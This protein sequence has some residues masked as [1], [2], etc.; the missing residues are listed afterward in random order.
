MT[1]FTPRGSSD[2]RLQP[3]PGPAIAIDRGAPA[4]DDGFRND[5][6]RTGSM[7]TM[8]GTRFSLS[9][10]RAEDITLED[11]AHALARCCR[12]G[13]HIGGLYWV[14]EHCLHVAAW[15]L[16]MGATLSDVTWGLLHDAEEAY[17]GDVIGPLKHLPE[18]AGYKALVAKFVRDALVPRFGL[19]PPEEPSM[20]KSV[21]AA[22]LNV[23]LATIRNI[24]NDQVQVGAHYKLIPYETARLKLPTAEAPEW[25]VTRFWLTR[26]SKGGI[27]TEGSV[28][29]SGHHASWERPVVSVG[30]GQVVPD[31]AGIFQMDSRMAA[32]HWLGMARHLGLRDMK[33]VREA[34]RE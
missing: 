12:Y 5:Q 31:P 28:T 3:D 8:G 18:M 33:D 29:L 32:R 24:V 34:R 11:L 23:E 21:D 7:L 1:N 30:A 19:H 25:W 13:G 2:W 6:E 4:Q 26:I 14:A 16:D 17:Y 27:L 9:D 10:P 15:L 22:L 20:V